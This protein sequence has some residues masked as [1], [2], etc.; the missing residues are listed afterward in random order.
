MRRE[1]SSRKQLI[2]NLKL[3]FK[4]ASQRTESHAA[5]VEALSHALSE[6]IRNTRDV[7]VPI[8]S[9][10]IVRSPSIT[11]RYKVLSGSIAVAIIMVVAIV[12]SR[13]IPT[14]ASIAKTYT[15]LPGQR[16]K[17]DIG[18]GSSVILAAGSRLTLAPGFGKTSR[19]VE[20][21]GQAL[22]T[23]AR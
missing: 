18:D 9:R 5:Q 21:E 10:N 1:D 4:M 13:D 23:V 22:F 11:A 14:T 6:H 7:S 8:V 2:E 20:L 16:A 12:W 17:I 3:L 15:T 19:T